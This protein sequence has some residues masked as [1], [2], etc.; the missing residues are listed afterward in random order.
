[1]WKEYQKFVKKRKWAPL[2]KNTPEEIVRLKRP[3]TLQDFEEFLLAT[4]EKRVDYPVGLH[5]E[6]E[7][8]FVRDPE[9]VK[10]YFIGKFTKTRREVNC[11]SYTQNIVVPEGVSIKIEKIDTDAHQYISGKWGEKEV[12]LHFTQD[13][14]TWPK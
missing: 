8:T 7:C 3:Q 11:R 9:K 12:R 6:H 14:F 5:S 2:P 10:N 1:M 13:N 4:Q